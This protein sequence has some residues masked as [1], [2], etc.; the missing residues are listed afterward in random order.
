MRMFALCKG[1]KKGVD[2][3]RVEQ[4]FYEKTYL[5]W[6]L[7]FFYAVYA[8]GFDR[9]FYLYIL[10]L[11]PW[12]YHAFF[13]LVFF[14]LGI[15]AMQ[16]FLK[17]KDC[18]ARM[19]FIAALSLL[20]TGMVDTGLNHVDLAHIVFGLIASL[21]VLGAV[22]FWRS[23]KTLLLFILF[24]V[25]GW[26]VIFSFASSFFQG[27][28]GMVL[29]LY[30][31]ASNYSLIGC[32]VLIAPIHAI[33]YMQDIILPQKYNRVYDI[34]QLSLIVFGSVP[35][36]FFAV[37]MLISQQVAFVN[38]FIYIWFGWTL[39]VSAYV[40]SR[41]IS[42]NAF[43]ANNIDDYISQ[44]SLLVAVSISMFIMTILSTIFFVG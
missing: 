32:V 4:A 10:E 44:P 25:L 26:C 12:K 33:T 19:F 35:I 13:V 20:F 6:V 27:E 21:V 11:R 39:P 14:A 9:F 37:L 22:V 16:N 24:Q 34:A 2:S 15:L 40:L 30:F 23:I 3:R 17:S 7:F 8:I 31:M 1:N 5:L 36:V 43:R 41:S 28:E 29:I 38:D 42:R 18:H